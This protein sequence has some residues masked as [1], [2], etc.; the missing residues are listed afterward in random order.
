MLEGISI[1]EL[2]S[3]L[4]FPIVAV[5][6]MAWFIFKIYKRS[7]EREDALREEIKENREVNAKA[8]ETIA[9]YAEKLDTIQQDISE[10]KTD[11]II[12]TERNTIE[13]A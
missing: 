7:E 2:I 9:K 5:I 10:I 8:L 4:G 11:I 13:E 6:A 12:L 1:I 3:T